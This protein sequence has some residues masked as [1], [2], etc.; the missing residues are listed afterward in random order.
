MYILDKR[1]LVLFVWKEYVSEIC[2]FGGGHAGELPLATDQ[3]ETLPF[4]AA[5]QETPPGVDMEPMISPDHCAKTKREQY[6]GVGK[7]EKGGEPDKKTEEK[8]NMKDVEGIDNDSWD[9][10][11]SST[12]KKTTCE[13][14]DMGKG[15]GSTFTESEAEEASQLMSIKTLIPS[16]QLR[17]F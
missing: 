10:K 7:D 1:C 17:N 11:G 12:D 8:N 3:Q 2:L 5:L 16:E 4:D 15:K 6:Q 9:G 14:S 13:S